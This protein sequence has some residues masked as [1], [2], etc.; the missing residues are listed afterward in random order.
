MPVLAALA[1]LGAFAGIAMVGLIGVSVTMRHLA[2]APLPYTEELVGLLMTAAFFLALPFVTLK[3]EHVRVSIL[4]ANLPERFRR[5]VGLAAALFGIVF[6]IWFFVL[7]LPWLEFAFSRNLKTE[8][9]RLLLY[10]WMAL[11]PF[12]LALTAVAFA[13][14]GILGAPGAPVDR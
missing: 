1:T 9:A 12:S 10:P 4:V 14:R 11:V 13:V 7:S 6:C 2:N 3:A 8:A 5:R